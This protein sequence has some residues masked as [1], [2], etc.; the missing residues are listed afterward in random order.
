MLEDWMI[1]QVP[2]ELKTLREEAMEQ[3]R[4]EIGK[5]LSPE[6][7]ETIDSK[8]CAERFLKACSENDFPTMAGLMGG[9]SPTLPNNWNQRLKAADFAVK[10][11]KNLPRPWKLLMASDILRIPLDHKVSENKARLILACMDPDGVPPR[12]G[13]PELEQITL[14]LTK[15]PDGPWIVDLPDSFLTLNQ[16]TADELLPTPLNEDRIDILRQRLD[17][18]YPSMAEKNP[19]LARDRLLESFRSDNS[20]AWISRFQHTAEGN[21]PDALL[22]KA[23][24]IRRTFD[25]TTGLRYCLPLGDHDEEG[26]FASVFQI[27]SLLSPDRF[28]LQILYFIQ[29][30]DG[31]AWAPSPDEETTSAFDSWRNSHQRKWEEQWR[32]TLL[33]ECAFLKEIPNSEAPPEAEAESLIKRW[34]QAIQEGDIR[35]ALRLTARLNLPDSGATLLRNLAYEIQATRKHGNRP[36]LGIVLSANPWTLVTLRPIEGSPGKNTD[37]NPCFPV[38]QTPDGPRILLET[39]LLESGTRTRQY[40][41]KMS[42]KRLEK[43]NREIAQTL[44]D[45]FFKHC[46]E[47]PNL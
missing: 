47:R 6:T 38:I 7:L 20:L 37:G 13:K 27:F 25:Q 43:F 2:V 36:E 8:S 4:R 40:L 3:V 5:S 41:N 23:L 34:F 28:E 42:I 14:N 17:S 39:D 9:A 44:K 19:R 29:T 46:E 30:P 1:E 31:W 22:S 33:D 35:A 18:L 24:A 16:K 45:L 11:D 15:S 10:A 21:N 26:L 32:N 12:F